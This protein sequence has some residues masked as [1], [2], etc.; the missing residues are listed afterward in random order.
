MSAIAQDI[1]EQ[2][3]ALRLEIEKLA[4]SDLEFRQDR[5]DLLKEV[6]PAPAIDANQTS[7]QTGDSNKGAQAVGTRIKIQIG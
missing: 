3:D 6:T 2:L 7:T 5:A 1:R 4:G